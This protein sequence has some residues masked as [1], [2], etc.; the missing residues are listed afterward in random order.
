LARR[1]K[2]TINSVFQNSS[3][4]WKQPHHHVLAER[5]SGSAE[6]NGLTGG[7]ARYTTSGGVDVHNQVVLR[8]T[9]QDKD[10]GQIVEEG[11]SS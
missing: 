5:R 3:W 10:V 8:W 1:R 11:K 6:R 2:P 7:T 4:Y 9:E